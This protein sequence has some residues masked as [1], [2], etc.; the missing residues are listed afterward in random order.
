MKRWSP[1]LWSGLPLLLVSIGL[2]LTD[3]H[4]PLALWIAIGINLTVIALSLRTI[5]RLW[6]LSRGM[7]WRP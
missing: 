1:L 3:W 2:L 6:R 4:D 5:W 7:R